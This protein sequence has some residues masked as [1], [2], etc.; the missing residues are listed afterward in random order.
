MVKAVV[1]DLDGTL[2]NT[3]EDLADSV[4]YTMRHFHLP[5]KT[6]DEVRTSV[7]N[8]GRK[9]M[10]RVI[11]GGSAHPE[12]EKIFAFYT[13]W[14]ENHCQIKTRPYEGVIELLRLLKKRGIG[15]A[16]VSN[17]GDGAVQELYDLY[18]RDLVD[19]AV[20]EREAMGIRRK[21]CPDTVLEAVRRLGCGPEEAVYVGDSEVDYETAR[22]AGMPC[23]L[24]TWGFRTAQD[25]QALHPDFLI[26]RAEDFRKLPM[27]K[28]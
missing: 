28:D 10:E 23:V 5:E 20:G 18:F 17:K 11:P 13:P 25:L 21:P 12:F 1:F 15:T 9:L 2:L 19:T 8:G 6:I 27:F 16:I 22:A 26:D 14:Y 4:N 3:L 7:G 24:V